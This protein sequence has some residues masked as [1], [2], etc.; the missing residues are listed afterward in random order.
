MFSALVRK[1]N[2]NDKM[3]ERAMVVTDSHIYKLDSKKFKCLTSH[4]IADVSHR[5]IV[6]WFLPSA[7]AGVT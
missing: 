4:P 7:S 2:R 3:A 5:G 1:F 6:T